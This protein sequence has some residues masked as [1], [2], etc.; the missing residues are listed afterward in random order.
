MSRIRVTLLYTMPILF[1]VV[2]AL[3]FLQFMSLN[4]ARAIS[5]IDWLLSG[6]DNIVATLRSTDTVMYYVHRFILK[7][8]FWFLWSAGFV[9]SLYLLGKHLQTNNDMVAENAVLVGR[10]ASAIMNRITRKYEVISLKADDVR[11]EKKL[12]ELSDRFCVESEFGYGTCNVIE[13]E[14]RIKI[15]LVI[16]EEQIDKLEAMEG[17]TSLDVVRAVVSDIDILLKERAELKKKY[18]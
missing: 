4:Y 14:H 18:A 3:A 12:K 8:S 5:F 9:F 11:L 17:T 15:K 16:L 7:R 13:C 10:E 2:G 6:S 1:L